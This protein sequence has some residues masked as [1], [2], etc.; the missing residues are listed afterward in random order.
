MR[1]GRIR[2]AEGGT[3]FLDEIADTPYEFQI[4]LLRLLQNKT[5]YRVGSDIPV[6]PIDVRFIF[7]TNRNL[8]KMIEEGTLREDFYDRLTMG[9]ML[10]VP[11]LRQRLA[12]VQ[13]LARQFAIPKAISDEAVDLLMSVHDWPGNVRQLEAV[14]KAAGSAS[15]IKTISKE[16]VEKELEVRKLTSIPV[17]TNLFLELKQKY[18]DGVVSSKQMREL[19]IEKFNDFHAWSKVARHLGCSTPEQVKS[20]QQW[21]FHLQRQGILPKE[22]PTLTDG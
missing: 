19:L 11:P 14:V 17:S 3:L 10:F 16:A 12:D 1:E 8:E 5:F 9:R 7:A 15:A 13:L 20:F 2:R 21:I 6:G 18:K 22:K 4:K